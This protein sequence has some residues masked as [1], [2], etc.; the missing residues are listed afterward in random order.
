NQFGQNWTGRVKEGSDGSLTYKNGA[1]DDRGLT[2]V[3][4]MDGT[5]LYRPVSG[6]ERIEDKQGRVIQTTNATGETY[7]FHY[8][9]GKATVPTEVAVP[10]GT[11]FTAE[12]TGGKPGSVHWKGKNPA[13]GGE[14]EW[15]GNVSFNR[16][17]ELVYTDSTGVVVTEKLDGAKITKDYD[18]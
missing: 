2:V 14:T 13:T 15:D 11:V 10:D 18:P 4:R 16:D 1:G 9:D 12:S 8:S 17:K 7:K 5:R 3:E 6:G